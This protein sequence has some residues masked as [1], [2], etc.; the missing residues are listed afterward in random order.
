[1]ENKD[2]IRELEKLW[3]TATDVS[4]YLKTQSEANAQLHMSKTVMYPPLT[5]AAGLA[6]TNLAN[7][8]T[9]LRL[10]EYGEN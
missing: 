5:S 1:M 10:E 8:I 2:L 7:L 6:A 4:Q 3:H 9:R